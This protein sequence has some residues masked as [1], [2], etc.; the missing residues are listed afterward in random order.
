[1]ED[2]VDGTSCQE[3]SWKTESRIQSRKEWK[4]GEL[5]DFKESDIQV[6]HE[7]AKIYSEV[8]ASHKI[9][10]IIRVDHPCIEE[11]SFGR[12]NSK[13]YSISQ[14]KV[15]QAQPLQLDSIIVIVLELETDGALAIVRCLLHSA[16]SHC[17]PWSVRCE[18]HASNALRCHTSPVL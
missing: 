15:S 9:V 14:M 17:S 8:Y 7:T 18:W 16:A 10:D 12:D 4:K 5:V 3:G 13:C 1:M 2:K 11:M 6:A